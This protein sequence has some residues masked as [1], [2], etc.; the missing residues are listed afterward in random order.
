MMK[1]KGAVVV[2]LLLA[3]LLAGSASAQEPPAAPMPAATPKAEVSFTLEPVPGAYQYNEAGRKDPFDSLLRLKE[4]EVDLSKLPE[5]QR[6]ETA[7]MQIKGLALVPGKEPVAMLVDPATKKYYYVKPGDLVGRNQG[8][9]T[10]IS[11]DGIVIQEKFKD[12]LG[13]ITTR[14]VVLRTSKPLKIDTKGGTP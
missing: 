8:E 5:I 4:I 7:T 11:Q 10:R 12:F 9:V 14:D 3:A 1:T 13:K 6:L 2:P